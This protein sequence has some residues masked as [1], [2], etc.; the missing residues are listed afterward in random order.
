MVRVILTQVVGASSSQTVTRLT[1][2]PAGLYVVRYADAGRCI[3]TKVC[4][5]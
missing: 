4:R 5:E 2:L 1:T 3:T